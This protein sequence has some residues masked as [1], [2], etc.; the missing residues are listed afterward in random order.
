MMN[1]VNYCIVS[2]WGWRSGGLPVIT[3]ILRLFYNKFRIKNLIMLLIVLSF[4]KEEINLN[5][6]ADMHQELWNHQQHNTLT[7]KLGVV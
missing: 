6:M 4:T 5:Q 2:V 7:T 3:H 1:H